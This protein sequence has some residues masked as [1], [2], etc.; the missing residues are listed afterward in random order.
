MMGA[1]KLW[2]EALIS[3][4]EAELQMGNFFNTFKKCYMRQTKIAFG[5]AVDMLRKAVNTGQLDV[6][7]ERLNKK[8][9]EA[10]EAEAINPIGDV[11]KRVHELRWRLA[12][13]E[14]NIA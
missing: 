14:R 10:G 5:C 1:M 7:F 12:D 8:R 6:A 13:Y 3:L 11:A 9:R 2:N 4:A